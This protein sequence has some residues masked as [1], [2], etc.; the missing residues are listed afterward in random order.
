MANERKKW[1]AGRVSHTER[2]RHGCELGGVTNDD[3][4]GRGQPGQGARAEREPAGDQE[5]G[6]GTRRRGFGYRRRVNPEPGG[7]AT[8]A[9]T[10][11]RTFPRLE[12]LTP[13]REMLGRRAKPGQRSARTRGR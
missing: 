12:S 13:T 5:V 8:I 3:V 6:S 9:L 10:P 2:R 7:P 4:A 1:V 11:R